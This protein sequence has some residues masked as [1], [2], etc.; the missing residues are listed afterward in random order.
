[1]PELYPR[2]VTAVSLGRAQA[3]FGAETDDE[4]CSI[5]VGLADLGLSV[6]G[7][8][9]RRYRG[10]LTGKCRIR[11]SMQ[12]SDEACQRALVYSC[13]TPSCTG[14]R[15]SG[16]I[17]CAVWQERHS[18]HPPQAETA[19]PKAARVNEFTVQSEPRRN[20]LGDLMTKHLSQIHFACM[21]T[22]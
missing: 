9:G 14:A 5:A 1:M 16:G 11:N 3:W 10:S 8:A 22:A 13:F 2:P 15:Q 7:P 21:V 19:G 17:L 4:S 20:Y 18:E 12:M 6:V